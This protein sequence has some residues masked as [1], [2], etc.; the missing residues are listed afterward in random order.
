MQAGQD[1]TMVSEG[2]LSIVLTSG[3]ETLFCNE[4]MYAKK[5]LSL[6]HVFSGQNKFHLIEKKLHSKIKF[7]ISN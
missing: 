4:N 2:E 6:T 5:F 1:E 3:K 7:Q